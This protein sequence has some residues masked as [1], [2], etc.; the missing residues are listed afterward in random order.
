MPDRDIVAK[1]LEYPHCQSGPHTV[2]TGHGDS[3]VLV[4]LGRATPQRLDRDAKSALAWFGAWVSNVQNAALFFVNDLGRD[5]RPACGSPLVDAVRNPAKDGESLSPQRPRC[6]GKVTVFQVEKHERKTQWK[7]ISRPR[8]HARPELVEECKRSP[9]VHL[10]VGLDGTEID[11]RCA[12]ID[13]GSGF[14]ELQLSDGRSGR[15]GSLIPDDARCR[16]DS[17]S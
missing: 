16:T 4:Q 12:L 3:L 13:G 8:C 2:A 11:I 1:A 17:D 6:I 7:T 14:L 9:N 5:G 15:H 10:E